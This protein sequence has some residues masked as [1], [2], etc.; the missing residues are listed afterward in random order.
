MKTFLLIEI[1]RF[2][3]PN[4]AV[5][6]YGE[7]YIQLN[8]DIQNKKLPDNVSG[9]LIAFYLDNAR[10]HTASQTYNKRIS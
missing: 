5:E 1:G 3:W 10:L 4:E 9:T 2:G 7:Q 6:T 8:V